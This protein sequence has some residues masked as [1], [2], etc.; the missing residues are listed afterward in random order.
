MDVV[1]AGPSCPHGS[2]ISQEAEQPPFTLSIDTCMFVLQFYTPAKKY[3]EWQ[4]SFSVLSL[5]C[6]QIPECAL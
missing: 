1:C 4:L 6:M 3:V 2:S 5:L